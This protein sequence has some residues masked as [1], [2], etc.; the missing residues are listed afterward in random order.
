MLLEKNEKHKKASNAVKHLELLKIL[1][2]LG[3]NQDLVPQ[4]FQ[5]RLLGCI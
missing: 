4:N 3:I 1:E 2:I 5:S